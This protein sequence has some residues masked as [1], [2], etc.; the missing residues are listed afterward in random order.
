M[1]FVR[2]DQDRLGL[3]REEGVVDLTGRLGLGSADPL[4]EYIE[5]GYDAS[6]YADAPPDHAREAVRLESPIRRP[7]KVI[8]APGNYEDHIR[9]AIEDED[10]SVEEYYSIEDWGYFLKATSS[11]VG[12]EDRIV[13][14]F[15]DRRCDHEV[16][17]AYL[18]A[19]DVK[20]VDAADAWDHI[21]GYTVLIDVSVRG[22]QDRSSRKSHDT[23]TVVGPAVV[24]PDEL[25]DPQ[26][27]RMQLS[28]N[29]EVRQDASTSNMIYDCAEFVQYA[30]I[31]TTLEAGD[32]LTTGTPSG[33]GPLADGDT[34]HAEIEGI[35]SMSL[36]VEAV[37][38]SY[39]DAAP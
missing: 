25:G 13:L 36:P 6:E 28:V 3:L 9:E 22:D 10:V 20:D 27:L 5:E 12:P 4:R 34:V 7:G 21:F 19:E 38:A 11:I 31:G 23:F 24:T 32:I 17:L 30:S 14:P 18:M 33:V 29:D 8:A 26:D 1:R 37:D 2:Y 35:G 15:T 16:E 39:H